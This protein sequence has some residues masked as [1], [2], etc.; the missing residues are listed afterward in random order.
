MSDPLV[1]MKEMA[2]RRERR[3][4]VL[5]AAERVVEAVTT[6][7]EGWEDTTDGLWWH[8]ASR[9]AVEALVKAWRGEQ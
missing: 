3:Q 6:P 1:A 8:D 7:P 4:R 9:D 5:D 2:A